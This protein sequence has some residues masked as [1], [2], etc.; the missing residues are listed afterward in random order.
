[1]N[2]DLVY[3]QNCLFGVKVIKEVFDTLHLVEGDYFNRKYDP[4]TK[5]KSKIVYRV[6]KNELGIGYIVFDYFGEEHIL[7]DDNMMP[8]DIKCEVNI[9]VERSSHQKPFIKIPDHH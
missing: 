6:K 2:K 9:D 7:L 4:K 1:M 8:L 5:I 3:Y